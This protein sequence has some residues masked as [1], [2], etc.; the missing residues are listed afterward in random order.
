MWCYFVPDAS[1]ISKRSIDISR[2]R[3]HGVLGIGYKVTKV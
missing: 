3:V 2:I 1:C